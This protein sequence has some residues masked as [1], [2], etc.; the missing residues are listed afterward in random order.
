MKRIWAGLA[1]WL[2][3]ALLAVLLTI[4]IHRRLPS[5]P[6]VLIWA[7]GLLVFL[8]LTIA[9]AAPWSWLRR[10]TLHGA[11]ISGSLLFLLPFLWLVGTTFKYN[12]EIFVFPPHWMPAF[13][14]AVH[15]SPYIVMPPGAIPAPAGLAPGQWRTLQAQ[16][17]RI[18]WHRAAQA[19]PPRKLALAGRAAARQA[20]EKQLLRQF[21][22]ATPPAA[23][24]HQSDLLAA[25]KHYVT[26]AIARQAFQRIFRGLVFS[27]LA[28]Q[29]INRQDYP[30]PLSIIHWHVRGP[31]QL[32]R[33]R[34]VSIAY[35]FNR[36][37]RFSIRADFP[38]PKGVKTV[39]GV[40]FSLQEDRSWHHLNIT[41][42]EN[43]QRYVNR[44]A[45]YLGAK[46]TRAY[47][48]KIRRRS[49]SDQSSLGIWPL[50]R[51]GSAGAG[52][53][54]DRPGW[55][56]LELTVVRSSPLA[57]AFYKYTQTYRDAWFAD[58]HWLDYLRNSVLL[59]VLNILMT[60]IS[61]SMAAYAFARLRWPG[62]DTL[63]A[64]VL[65][66][67]MLPGAVTMIPVFLIFKHLGWYNTLL[68]LWVPAA[69]GNAF[70]IFLLRQF[71]KSIPRELEEAALIDGCGWIGIYW[72]IIL[73]LMKPAL[74]AVAIFTFQGS[75]NDFMG[76]LI[77][78][79][80]KRLYP[81]SMGL[82]TFQ[83]EHAS[84][85]G[86]LM[87]ASTILILPVVAI[88]F[89]AQRYFIQGVTL[90]GIKG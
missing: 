24:S 75:W 43:G 13:P 40:D 31:A 55:I 74:A 49:P 5:N 36:R 11:L 53:A 23:W 89:V 88:F 37:Q 4:L 8:S 71:M 76:P 29:S 41:L 67:M 64:I 10:I 63:F 25:A 27:D 62:R 51:R 57:A 69:F 56:R 70:F 84:Q 19:V 47:S 17:R 1:L 26:A 38:R 34:H 3:A 60:L 54:Y 33:G 82:F 68:P 32:F 21:I 59:V 90:T 30:V 20:L 87:A 2:E 7:G 52:H 79:N 39:L 50:V 77:Y 78:L 14:R 44:N 46:D 16:M 61:C 66:T 48:L 73:P 65:G 15:R 81:L 9:M 6:A 18:F 80:S 85:F 58:T 42:E 12:S 45:F 22:A 86:M 35:H 83:N 72:R 28:I